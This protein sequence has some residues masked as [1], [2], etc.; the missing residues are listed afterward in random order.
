MID[1]I[2][3]LLNSGEHYGQDELIE[4]AKGKYKLPMSIKEKREQLKR[5]KECRLKK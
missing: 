5:E 2:L 3:E 4:I 1:K